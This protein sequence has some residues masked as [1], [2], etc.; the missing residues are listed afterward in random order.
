MGVMLPLLQ[1]VGSSPDHHELSNMMESGL[2]TSSASSLRTHGCISSGPMD[3]CTFKFLRK[4]QNW[5]S[6]L[7]GSSSFS[8]SLAFAFCNLGGMA[9]ALAVED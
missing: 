9:R 8:Q 5:S 3:L 1:S 6:P 7:V 2:A 4:S